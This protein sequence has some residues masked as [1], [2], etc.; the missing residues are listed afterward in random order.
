MLEVFGP[1][2]S[3]GEF[4][5]GISESGVL[6]LRFESGKGGKEASQKKDPKELRVTG[7]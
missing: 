1:L 3:L 5:G 6:G 2:I 7:E 4:T